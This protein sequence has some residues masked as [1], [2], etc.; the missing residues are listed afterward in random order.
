MGKRYEKL[1]LKGSA[2]PHANQFFDIVNTLLIII[3]SFYI[4]YRRA[5]RV[6]FYVPTRDF[7]VHS[8]TVSLFLSPS[9]WLGLQQSSCVHSHILPL[10]YFSALWC[11]IVWYTHLNLVVVPNCALPSCTYK[12]NWQLFIFATS[13][14]SATFFKQLQTDVKNSTD[15]NS[16]HII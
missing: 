13:S 15:N 4:S 8:C 10:V 6:Y 3:I 7:T 16:S 1:S 12:L 11:S 2:L 14:S 9:C 5:S